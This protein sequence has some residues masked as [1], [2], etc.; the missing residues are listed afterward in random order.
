M[1]KEEGGE[2][3]ETGAW[4]PRLDVRGNSRGA[5]ETEVRVPWSRV[6]CLRKRWE[7]TNTGVRSLGL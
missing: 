6:R 4:G 5:T 2:A 3:V 7:A 1:F